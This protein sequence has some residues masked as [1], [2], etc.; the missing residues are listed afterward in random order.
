MKKI[1]VILGIIF[2]Q[3]IQAQDLS[4]SINDVSNKTQTELI[5]WRRHF[6]E[7]PELSNREYNT[8][9]YIADYLNSLGLEVKYP[10]A[11]TG[12]L[13]ILKGGKPGPNIGLRAD[14]D[15]LPVL[16]RTPVSFASK[17]K[18]EYNGQQVN[19][20]HACGHDAHTAILMATAKALKAM[21]KK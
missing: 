4:K 16:E 10:I 6:H 15:A 13:A 7:F 11:K 14:I 9:K 8:G 2:C 19:V 18:A 3:N 21:Q 1:Y 5:N 20:M 17:V 12:V